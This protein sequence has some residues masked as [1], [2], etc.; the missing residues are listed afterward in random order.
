MSKFYF[1]SHR[2]GVKVKTIHGTSTVPG[3]KVH[4]P[5]K[6]E[7][8]MMPHLERAV[9]LL[10]GNGGVVKVIEVEDDAAHPEMPGLL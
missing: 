6:S 7:A 10:R 2:A 9:C 3:S 1:V 4:G 5:Y 8:D